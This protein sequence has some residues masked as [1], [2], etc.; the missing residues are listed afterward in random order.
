MMGP[1][2]LALGAPSPKATSPRGQQRQ[3]LT[4]GDPPSSCKQEWKPPKPTHDPG[5]S[6]SLA[7]PLQTVEP[8]P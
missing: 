5:D 7:S 1:G 6:L 8:L 2:H 4:L 3:L